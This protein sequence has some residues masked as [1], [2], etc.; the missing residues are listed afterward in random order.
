MNFYD[1]KTQR[2]FPAVV[3]AK[4]EKDSKLRPGPRM[5]THMTMKSGILYLYG[6]I[7]EQGDRSY[8]L[9]DLWSLDI[10]KMNQWKRI[11][12]TDKVDW[13]GSDKGESD[14]EEEGSGDEDEEEESDDS[15]PGKRLKNK[16][17]RTWF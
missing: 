5:N 1:T 13:E 10:K 15:E 16:L 14:S 17:T 6:G 8:V 9:N 12:K 11:N 3:K 7:L 4:D 2:W